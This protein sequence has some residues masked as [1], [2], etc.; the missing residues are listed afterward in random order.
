MN[1]SPF[2]PLSLSPSPNRKPTY[3]KTLYIGPSFAQSHPPMPRSSDIKNDLALLF[4]ILV[5]GFNFPIIKAVLALMHPHAMN[6]FRLW[7]AALALGALHYVYQKRAGE[8]FFAP[9]RTH[10][11]RL[12]GLGLIG[13][14]F[15]Q[16]CFIVGVDNTTAGSAALIMASAPLWTAVFG[17]FLRFDTLRPL[18]WIGLLITFAGAVVI[19]VGGTKAID[20]GDTTFFGNVVMT[21]AAVFWGAYTVL[22]KPLTR[23]LSPVAITFL[24]L[25]FALPFLTMLAIPYFDSVEWNRL[26]GW[27]W[28][29]IIFS[30]SLSTGLTVVIW[31]N[32][33]KNVGPSHTAVYGNLVP[34]VALFSGAWLLAEPILLAQLAGGVLI[35]GGLFVMRRTRQKV[36]SG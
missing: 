18:A 1:F 21:V 26:N 3:L 9:L 13:Y 6:V 19:V 14:L 27:I 28:V 23:Q 10:G 34:F 33:V 8:A 22:S 36:L 15:Y 12:F 29:A 17:H 11:W 7:A 35:L 20:F 32:S 16:F 4:V 2:P 24:G 30:G 31:N 5:W 25:L